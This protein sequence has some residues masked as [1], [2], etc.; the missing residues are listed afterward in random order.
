MTNC[1]EGNEWKQFWIKKQTKLLAFWWHLTVAF[2]YSNSIKDEAVILP[3]QS[4]LRTRQL[5]NNY[6]KQFI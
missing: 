2:L 4:V 6:G 5:E 3:T 1:D